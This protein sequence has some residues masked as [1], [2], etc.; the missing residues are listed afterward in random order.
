MRVDDGFAGRMSRML[1]LYPSRA[2]AAEVA[3]ISTDRLRDYERNGADPRFEVLARLATP[4]DVSLEWLAEGAGPMIRSERGAGRPRITAELVRVVTL[5]WL[6]ADALTASRSNEELAQTIADQ[7]RSMSGAG[8]APPPARRRPA[9]APASDAPPAPAGRPR[10]PTLASR[11]PVGDIGDPQLLQVLDFW[12]EHAPE[13]VLHR[14]RRDIRLLLDDDRIP[15][16]RLCIIQVTA[17][18]PLDWPI[19]FH[20]QF[21]TW[22]DQPE[23]TLAGQVRD[24][25][26]PA[27]ARAT[28][29][30][31]LDLIDEAAPMVHRITLVE[32]DHV[33]AYD[34]L[35]LPCSHRPGDPI[36]M[37]IT[38]SVDLVRR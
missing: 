18:D 7:C 32:D 17:G 33:V 37:I 4:H 5:Y 25:P 10:H 12:R 27:V 28:A 3:G 9:A 38:V 8:A 6:L 2:A 35:A 21:K 31:Y 26:Y 22:K 24:H 29:A 30:T 20:G 14:S 16:G 13:G 11:Y 34:R 23:R 36:D 15:T 19:L 1:D